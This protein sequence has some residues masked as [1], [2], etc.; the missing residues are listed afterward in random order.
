MP[1]PVEL[2]LKNTAA[3]CNTLTTELA[4]LNKRG[5]TRMTN[6]D[7]ACQMYYT[8]VD[9]I[10][11]L[12]KKAAKGKDP[13]ADSELKKWQG[14][15]PAMGVRV[16]STYAELQVQREGLAQAKKVVLAIGQAIDKVNKLAARTAT[17]DVDESSSEL[18]T[19]VQTMA[20]SLKAA[21]K[22]ITRME[23]LL[24]DLPNLP[25]L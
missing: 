21:S 25:R 7:N 11:E 17:I 20:S 22:E 6:Y 15:H 9:T 1:N 8:S 18:Q 16:K 10:E 4:S 23:K 14:N 3:A 13:K 19:E 24:D 12:K 2:A 5:K